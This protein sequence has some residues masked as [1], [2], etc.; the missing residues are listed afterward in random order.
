MNE[1]FVSLDEVTA[2]IKEELAAYFAVGVLDDTMYPKWAESA[3]KD[4]RVSALP[5][6]KAPLIV[7]NY[8]ADLPSDFKQIDKLWACAYQ[9]TEI[10]QGHTSF[11]YQ[12][13][14][15]I[16]PIDDQCNEC[17]QDGENCKCNGTWPEKQEKYRV[18]H[19]V[20]GN[21][22]YDYYTNYLLKPSTHHTR[23]QCHPNSANLNCRSGDTFTLRDCKVIV[24]FPKGFL[25]LNYYGKNEDEYG[26]IL[27]EDNRWIKDYLVLY[28]KYKSFEQL[29][30]STSDETS[31]QLQAKMSFYMQQSN[32]A[33]VAAMDDQKKLDKYQVAKLIKQTRARFNVYRRTMR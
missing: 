28:L 14:C 16:T 29:W 21:H 30:N 1:K 31:N 22:L 10:L 24:N 33:K 8:T 27:I 12:T 26:N 23:E 25:H 13:D 15:R 4:F 2:T 11:Y 7:E 5:Q 6:K 19:K 9:G 18:T 20:T 3:M 32:E 17:F